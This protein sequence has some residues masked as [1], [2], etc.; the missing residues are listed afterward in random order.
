[1]KILPAF[2]KYEKFIMQVLIVMMSVVLALGIL[3]LGWII[4]GD[5]IEP[6][7]LLLEASQLLDIFGLFMLVIIGVE[8]LETLIKTYIAPDKPHF[9]IVLSV[10]I[11]AI[12]RKVII[13]DLKEVD[14]LT[15]FGIAAIIISLTVGYYFMKKVRTINPMAIKVSCYRRNY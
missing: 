7:F 5:I 4:L 8:L 3:D 13:L 1:M 14:G 11:I 10:A 12:A 2:K 15:L 6:P 9:E